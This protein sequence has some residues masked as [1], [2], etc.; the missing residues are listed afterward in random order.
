MKDAISYEVK[1][2]A[3]VRRTVLAGREWAPKADGSRGLEY[4]PQIEKDVIED[5]E[6]YR[7]TFDDLDVRE[8]ARSLNPSPRACEA[9]NPMGYICTL[10]VGHPGEHFAQGAPAKDATWGK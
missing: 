6:V 7:Q 1:I 3:R 4:T 8:V 10:A 5:A 9:L 2:T